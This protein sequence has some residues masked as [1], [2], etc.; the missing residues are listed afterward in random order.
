MSI[1]N[2]TS[3]EKWLQGIMELRRVLCTFGVIGR[4]MLFVSFSRGKDTILTYRK[5]STQSKWKKTLRTWDWPNQGLMWEL[6]LTDRQY[7]SWL[8]AFIALSS[9]LSQM[10]WFVKNIILVIL[11]IST[12][13]LI[14]RTN[15]AILT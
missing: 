3:S 5:S 9:T 1:I 8:K 2:C 13:L 6:C 4:C 14:K 11:A 15:A 12:C 7:L 10:I